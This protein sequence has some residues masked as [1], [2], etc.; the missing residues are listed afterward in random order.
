MPPT[1]KVGSRPAVPR[2]VATIEVVVVLPRE[3]SARSEEH[4]SEL[5]SLTNLVCR[6][7]LEK[8]KNHKACGQHQ[9]HFKPVQLHE[10]EQAATRAGHN[11]RHA[12]ESGE[13]SALPRQKLDL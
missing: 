5:Q 6:L 8:K 11:H 3:P 2:T 1:T 12:T 10:V 4:T 7:L 13:E 9:R